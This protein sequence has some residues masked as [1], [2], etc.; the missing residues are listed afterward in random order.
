M[1]IL[2][3]DGFS[4]EF[5]DMSWHYAELIVFLQLLPICVKLYSDCK[6]NLYVCHYWELKVNDWPQGK[7]W[8]LIPQD[9]H[10]F[11]RWNQGKHWGRVET[12]LTVSWMASHKVFCFTPEKWLKKN[13]K[14]SFALHWLGYKF[15][16]VSRSK[17][18]SHASRKFMSLFPLGVREF[19]PTTHNTFSSNQKTNLSWEVWQNC[20]FTIQIQIKWNERW[21][22]TRGYPFYQ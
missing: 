2:S 9:P 13:M 15:A 22:K 17:T 10:C 12:K 11:L 16:T 21:K 18:W 7:Q 4:W 3:F 14:K 8:V 5:G 20:L 1:T 6:E 19:C